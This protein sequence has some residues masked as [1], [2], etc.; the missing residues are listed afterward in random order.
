VSDSDVFQSL[1]SAS[2]VR[3]Y[4]QNLRPVAAV[5]G[6]AAVR[7][8]LAR[9]LAK[10]ASVNLFGHNLIRV[11]GGSHRTAF[12]VNDSASVCPVVGQSYTSLSLGPI[13]GV[14]A[15]RTLMKPAIALRFVV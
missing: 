8:F 1:G 7:A 10:N 11:V 13:G 2:I 6:S 4:P 15:S 3:E 14:C 12:A 5:D 9:N